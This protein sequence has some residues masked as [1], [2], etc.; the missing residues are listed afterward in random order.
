MICAEIPVLDLDIEYEIDGEKLVIL[1]DEPLQCRPGD[2]IIVY[3]Y[4]NTSHGIE[5]KSEAKLLEYLGGRTARVIGRIP[6]KLPSL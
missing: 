6:Y 3:S 4:I 1:R 2:R 5:I